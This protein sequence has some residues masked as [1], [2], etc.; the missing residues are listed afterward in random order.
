MKK[1]R[2]KT[3]L[4]EEAGRMLLDIGRIVLAGIV[5]VEILRGQIIGIDEDMLHGILLITGSAI[6]IVCYMFGLF[7][8]K[9]EIKTEKRSKHSL[10][11]TPIHKGQRRKRGKK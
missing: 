7:M 6:V 11:S 1:P 3:T 4:K 2:K 10:T 5:I 8:V 9:R